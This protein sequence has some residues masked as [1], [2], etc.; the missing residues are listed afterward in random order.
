M[1]KLISYLCSCMRMGTRLIH[2]SPPRQRI[3]LLTLWMRNLLTMG[4]YNQPNLPLRHSKI[5]LRIVPLTIRWGIIVSLA[6]YI[7]DRMLQA[8]S[9]D[10]PSS[11][12]DPPSQTL[13]TDNPV[14][15]VPPKHQFPGRSKMVLEVKNFLIDELGGVFIVLTNFNVVSYSIFQSLKMFSSRQNEV[16]L[17]SRGPHS[18]IH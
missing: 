2:Q 8:P 12:P 3:T 7:I 18:R 1:Q 9:Q 10:I 16:Y 14:R 17:R 4:I 11:R 13:P 6:I 5:R 15:P